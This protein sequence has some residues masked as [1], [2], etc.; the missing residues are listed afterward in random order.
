MLEPQTARPS[1]A[2]LA[3]G[4]VLPWTWAVEQLEQERN[5]W[6]VSVRTDGFP[7]ARPVW[8]AWYGPGLFLSLAGGGLRRTAAASGSGIPVTVH[9]DS[10][11]DVV[12]IEG[13]ADRVRPSPDGALPTYELDADVRLEATRRYNV[14]YRGGPDGGAN[15]N[16]LVRPSRVYG[17][18][19]NAERHGTDTA[20]RWD[21]PPT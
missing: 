18:T 10:A 15:V 21:F 13:V 19:E 6:L 7:Q 3:G 11:S 9:A 2:Y 12:I 17:W 8:G 14:K 5:F 1:P 4:D 16:F 20:T